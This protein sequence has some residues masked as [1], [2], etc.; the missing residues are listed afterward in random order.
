MPN[1]Y[2]GKSREEVRRLTAGMRRKA[3]FTKAVKYL[4]HALTAEP[5]FTTEERAQLA[6]RIYPEGLRK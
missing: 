6:L 4:D 2:S 3:R 5:A 1:Q